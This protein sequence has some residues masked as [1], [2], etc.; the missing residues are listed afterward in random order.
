MSRHLLTLLVNVD[1]ERL[2]N[3]RDTRALAPDDFDPDDRLGPDEW[4]SFVDVED[5]FQTGTAVSAEVLEVRD[6]GQPYTPHKEPLWARV[7]LLGVLAVVL[8]VVLVLLLL[9][10]VFG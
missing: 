3:L 1:D 10:R 5:A 4:E 7:N 2:R 9:G 8:A 6:G